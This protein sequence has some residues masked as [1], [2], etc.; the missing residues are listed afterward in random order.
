MSLTLIAALLLAQGVTAD[1]A[2]KEVRVPCKI[3]P[4]KLPNLPEVYPI[5]VIATLPAPKGQKA[6]ETIVTI[7]AM[8]SA[9]YKAL[10]SL[11]LKAGKPGRGEDPCAG[12]EMEVLLDLPAHGGLPA[13]TVRIE[14]VLLEKKTGRPLPPVKWHFTGSVMKEKVFG[15]DASGTLISV[16]PVTDEVVLQSGMGMREEGMIKLDTAK[17]LLPPEGTAATLVLRAASGPPPAAAPAGNDADRQVLKL[18]GSVGPGA[19]PPPSA[20]TGGAPGAASGSD[21]FEHRKE[22]RPG[23]DLPDSARP[24]D[25][26]APK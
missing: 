26:P 23:K 18:S 13:R 20:S 10:E 16:F 2:K 1:P 11:G 19:L 15:A 14:S 9:V 7:D 21:P 5:E 22:V 8:P 3:A 6:H 4:R 25:L 12:P 17:N 24:V